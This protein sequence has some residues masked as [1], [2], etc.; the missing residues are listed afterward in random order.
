MTLR[1][2]LLCVGLALSSHALRGAES[3]G[4]INQ[5]NFKINW[6]ARGI[7]GLA[8][9]HD[10]FGAQM[11]VRGQHLGLLV[12]YRVANGEWLEV[13][14]GE[15]HAA[16]DRNE[17]RY[18]GGVSNSPLKVVQTFKTDGETLD[19]D[20]DLET[21]TAAPVEIGDLAIS[22]PVNGPRGE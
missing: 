21:I 18:T 12:K 14:I 22:I 16:P 5:G 8:N 19:W 15:V 2:W 13:P 3:S 11:L 10:R 9:P 20:V 17:V 6:D 1:F 4:E 7:S